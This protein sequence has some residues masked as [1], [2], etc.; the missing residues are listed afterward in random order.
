MDYAVKILE[1]DYSAISGVKILINRCL[2]YIS[3]NKKLM[4]HRLVQ[5]MAKNIVRQ[6]LI[7]PANRSRVWLSCDSYKILKKGIG[8]ET[9]EGLALDMKTVL[10]EN[11]AFKPSNLK[12]DALKNMDSLKFLKLNFVELI[13]SYENLSEDL[14]WL[15]W[16]GFHL[17]TIPVDLCMGN[18]VAIDMSYSKLEVFE[19]PTDIHSLKILNLKDSHK[20]NE[21]R[22]II[23]IPNLETLILWNCYSL[24]NVCNTLGDLTSLELLNM[25]GC[26]TLGD[27]TKPT[28]P[29]PISLHQLFLKDCFLKHTTSFPL[30]FRVQLDLQYLNLGNSLFESLPCF[31]H[32]KKLRVLDLSFC[33]RLICL[34][35]L[36][37]TLAELYVYGCELIERITFQSARFTLQEFGYLGCIR[38]HEVEGFMKLIP[39]AK[40]DETDLGHMKWLKEHENHQVCLVGDDELTEGRSWHIQMLYEFGIMSTSMSVIEDPNMTLEYISNS[41][42]LYFDVPTC[43]KNKRL[44]GINVNFK[45]SLSGDD[46]VW[47]CKISTSNGVDLVY[48][49]KVFGKPEDD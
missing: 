9:V 33:S 32:L 25:T 13:G 24:V 26:N 19:P 45:Y 6:E 47:F 42:S 17:R 18:L 15:C 40:L 29:F 30:T 35:G 41:P 27:L 44:K 11:I 23:R 8:S 4:M 37:N 39:I 48:N 5:E 16:H 10:E 46:W 22:N 3:P 31:D 12:I 36:P 49:P 43:P 28:L 38:L 14:R 7:L 34:A 21:I 20:L 1:P 2:L